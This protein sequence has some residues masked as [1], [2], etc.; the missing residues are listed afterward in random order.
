MRSIPAPNAVTTLESL[1][2]DNTCE[3][4]FAGDMVCMLVDGLLERPDVEKVQGEVREVSLKVVTFIHT[5][6]ISGSEWALI[7]FLVWKLTI[8]SG[9]YMDRLNLQT[10]HHNQSPLSLH[11][12]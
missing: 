8:K 11:R 5:I 9:R 4:S 3:L 7:V 2:G 10:G 12:L 1:G 6:T